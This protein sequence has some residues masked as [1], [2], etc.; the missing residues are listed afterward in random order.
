MSQRVIDLRK[1]NL[2]SASA[3]APRMSTRQFNIKKANKISAT[4][5]SILPA[6]P[7]QSPLPN[8]EPAEKTSLSA[9][10][11]PIVSQK[12]SIQESEISPMRAMQ[13]PLTPQA[14]PVSLTADQPATPLIRE[15]EKIPLVP[16]MQV[17]AVI[18]P[19]NELPA[20]PALTEIENIPHTDLEW[21]SYEHENRIRGPYWFLYPLS[22]ATVG[23]VFGIITHSY[24]FV[25]LIIISFTLLSY[26]AHQT[27]RLL[28]YHIEK[29]G[30]WIEK[31][32]INFSQITSFWIYTHPLMTPELL[33]ETRHPFNHM[34]HIRLENVSTERIRSAL[35]PY[36]PEVKQ[37]DR[38][39]DQIARIIGF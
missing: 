16:L 20:A 5:I 35:L 25:L 1:K 29:R 11:T 33:L 21:T 4:P 37:K 7:L 30:I 28:T 6:T 8:T 2:Q 34:M 31:K 36:L 23:I 17:P 38:A 15:L 18:D 22:I 39:S 14:V 19:A 3:N 9:A 12:V 13:T 26:Y 10:R 27:P 32:L 24:L